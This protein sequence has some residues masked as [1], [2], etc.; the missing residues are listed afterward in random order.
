[1]NIVEAIQTRRAYRSLDPS[2]ITKEFMIDL[3]TNA[4]LS[5]S[6]FNNQPWRFIFIH[7]SETL[8]KIHTVLSKGNEWAQRA[9]LIIAIVSKKEYDCIIQE[10][11][12]YLFDCG[13]ATAFLILRATEL[14]FV[15]HPICGFDPKKTREILGIP[16]DL[17]VIALIIVGKHSQTVN[18][19]LSPKQIQSENKRPDRFPL[20]KFVSYNTFTNTE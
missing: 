5:P 1:M 2:G 15:A 16:N 3:A 10:R 12:Y 8:K 17:E 6:C 19:I 4:Q 13:M 9:S 14:G 11:T 18:P 7:N 20:E